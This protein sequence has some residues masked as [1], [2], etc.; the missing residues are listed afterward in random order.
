MILKSRIKISTS[1]WESNVC[2]PFMSDHIKYKVEVYFKIF[3]NKT[4]TTCLFSHCILRNEKRKLS[5]IMP[6]GF[7]NYVSAM[8]MTTAMRKQMTN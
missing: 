7:S 8:L 5:E 3:K 6:L 4:T 2:V 1:Y